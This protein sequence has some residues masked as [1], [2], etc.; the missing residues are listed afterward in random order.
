MNPIPLG[1]ALA[2]ASTGLMLGV[3]LMSLVQLTLGHRGPPSV[4]WLAVT[5]GAILAMGLGDRSSQ[6]GADAIYRALQPFSD[7]A[8]LVI[9]PALWLYV[10]QM[11]DAPASQRHRWLPAV[12]HLV[13]AASLWL[14]LAVVALISA[15]E[16]RETHR[17]LD[18]I[19]ILLP[20]AAQLVAY[21]VA[22]GFRVAAIRRRTMAYYSDL[23]GRDLAWI[24][25]MTLLYVAGV[26]SWIL[27]WRW[28]VSASNA[29][30]ALFVAA[31]TAW[32]GIRGSRQ[33]V[34]VPDATPPPAPAAAPAPAPYSKARLPDARAG[35][36]GLRLAAAMNEDKAYLE[37][38]LTLAELAARV[39]ATTHELSQYF[40]LHEQQS[41][42]DFVNRCRVEAVKATMLRPASARRPLIEVALECGFGS[43]SAFNSVFKRFTGMSPTDYRN[44]LPGTAARP[45]PGPSRP[46]G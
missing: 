15:P 14:L 30:T 37:S 7:A 35:E 19:V 46:T 17:S 22:L 44:G 26:A 9:G 18:E 28:T 21:A 5:V 6:L 4:T 45:M 33:R 42:Y 27:T 11:G 3:A 20:I 2:I 34:V 39:G 10:R 29:L 1:D 36:I 32:L 41:F 40:S 38:D 25:V 12:L 43:K 31:A 23:Q 24:L 13:P 16:P 8:L